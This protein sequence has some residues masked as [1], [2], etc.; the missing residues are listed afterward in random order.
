MPWW[1][2][3][4]SDSA[5]VRTERA[6][7]ISAVEAMASR[8]T[9]NAVAVNFVTRPLLQSRLAAVGHSLVERLEVFERGLG[10]VRRARAEVFVEPAVR[11]A[12]VLG[13]F[14]AQLPSEVFA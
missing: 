13:V 4:A 14:P 8:S 12:P 9:Q 1:F 11:C 5:Q 10:F 6:E 3:E 7:P 2:K